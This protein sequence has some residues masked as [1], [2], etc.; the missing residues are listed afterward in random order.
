MLGVIVSAVAIRDLAQRTSPPALSDFPHLAI[1]R[2]SQHFLG[3]F[4]FT[5]WFTVALLPGLLPDLLP[6][7]LS[8]LL[9][10]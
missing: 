1:H 4:W 10:G 5:S 6:C 3:T 7:L 8:G 9:P 2:L